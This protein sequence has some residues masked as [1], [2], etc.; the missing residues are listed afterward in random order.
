[1]VPIFGSST[2]P[3]FTGER[4]LQSLCNSQLPQFLKANFHPLPSL[5]SHFHPQPS[6]C[7]QHGTLMAFGPNLA[8]RVSFNFRAII[9]VAHCSNQIPENQAIQLSKGMYAIDVAPGLDVALVAS[10]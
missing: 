4:Y 8:L 10:P 3:T 7:L 6:A 9:Q 1:M 2:A 5:D